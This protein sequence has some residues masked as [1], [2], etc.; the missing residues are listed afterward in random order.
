M[1]NI[2]WRKKNWKENLFSNWFNTINKL[3]NNSNDIGK[4]ITKKI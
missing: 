1:K 3:L 2:L 4:T